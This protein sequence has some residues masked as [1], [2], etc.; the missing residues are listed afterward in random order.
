LEQE[1]QWLG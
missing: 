1:F